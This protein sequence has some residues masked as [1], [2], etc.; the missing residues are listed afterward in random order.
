M[1]RGVTVGVDHNRRMKLQTLP[2][3]GNWKLLATRA[4]LRLPMIG[5]VV[6]WLLAGAAVVWWLLAFSGRGSWQPVPVLPAPAVVADPAAV[7]RA[8]GYR[9]NASP[10]AAPSQPPPVSRLRLLGVAAQP[11]SQGAALLS[12][13]GQPP[14]PFRVGDKVADTWV[15]ESVDRQRVRLSASDGAGGAVELTLPPSTP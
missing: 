14:R 2:G 9:E 15:L 8:L 11:A 5:A 4:D 12:V 7:V 3:R 10:V 6:T 13:D 1:S